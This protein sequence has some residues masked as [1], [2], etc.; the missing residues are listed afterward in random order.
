[1]I[2]ERSRN[3]LA[4]I[5][6]ATHTRESI[7]SSLR[8]ST[9]Y[10]ISLRAICAFTRMRSYLRL[11]AHLFTRAPR[12][13]GI[14]DLRYYRRA[15]RYSTD[16]SIN[17]NSSLLCFPDSSKHTSRP[18][19]GIDCTYLRMQNSPKRRYPM[20]RYQS[21]NTLRSIRDFRQRCF[22]CR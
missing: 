8:H 13:R 3:A 11:R 19:R 5:I 7:P 4:C 10:A 1:V 2:K 12:P 22:H 21:S 9:S 6:R 17:R 15:R 18:S 14:P 20:A 16:V